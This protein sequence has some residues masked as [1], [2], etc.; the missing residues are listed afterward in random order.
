MLRAAAFWRPEGPRGTSDHLLQDPALA[1]YVEHWPRP[2]DLGV[3]AETDQPIGA[4]WC[5][6]FSV[7]DPG[8]GFVDAA[9]PEVAMGVVGPWR[10]RGV[11]RRLLEALMVAARAA[12]AP[13]LSLSVESDNLARRLYEDLGF[14]PTTQDGGSIT[15]KLD[16]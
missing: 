12:R 3:V 13:A 5:R 6:F 14:E 9:I 1:H 15:M 8:Y 4:A 16:L 2:G 10:G 7:D 11:G